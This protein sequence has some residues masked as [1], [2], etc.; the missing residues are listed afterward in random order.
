MASAK[1]KVRSIF[2]YTMLD[3]GMAREKAGEDILDDHSIP[4]Y[5]LSWEPFNI[6]TP[7]Q[8]IDMFKAYKQYTTF[9]TYTIVDSEK[10]VLNIENNYGGDV[11]F[12][13]GECK[14]HA[15]HSLYIEKEFADECFL[16]SSIA[17]Q[18]AADAFMRNATIDTPE[19]EV[20]NVLESDPLWL[21]RGEMKGTVTSTY[22]TINGKEVNMYIKTDDNHPVVHITNY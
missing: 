18:K 2:L 3:E 7:Q 20:R 9:F 10:P 21:D 8:I 6:D 15:N 19:S 1:V 16:A 4:S 11:S 14:V 17:R 13:Q 12:S 22:F 5:Y